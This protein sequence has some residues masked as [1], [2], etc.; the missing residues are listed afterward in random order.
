MSES[1]VFEAER[2]RL[3]AFIR[4]TLRDRDEAEDVLQDVY[5]EY[6][7]V[8][9]E[10][11]DQLGAWL[12]RVARNKIIDRFRRKKTRTEYESLLRSSEASSSTST[13]PDDRGELREALMEAIEALP[14]EQRDVF[15]WNELEG[16]TFEEIAQSTGVNVNTLLAR[17]RY[18]VQFLREYLKEIHDE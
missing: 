7:E 17:K 10:G 4:R 15:I 16:K 11:F 12:I 5:E 2:G 3:L 14:P 6:S 1:E 8:Y 9:S 18:A 13:A